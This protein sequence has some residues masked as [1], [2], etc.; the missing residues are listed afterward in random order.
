MERL[1]ELFRPLSDRHQQALQW[2]A[3]HMGTDQPWP[4][5]IPH[6]EGETFL[7]TKA[8]GIYKPNWTRYALSVRQT[9]GGPYPDR[10]PVLRDDGTWLYSYFQENENPSARDQE[11]TNLGL[12]ACLRD[13]V[14]IGVLRQTQAKPTVRYRVLGLALVSGWDAGYFFLEGFS[15]AGTANL[16]GP[17]SELELFVRK[18]ER[19]SAE[20]RAFEPSGILDS[21]ERTVAQ[22]VRRRGQPEF[23]RKL[24]AAYGNRCA[25]TGCDAVEALEASHI[26]P[27]MG[28]ETNRIVNGLLLRADI[29]T[30]FDMGLLAVQETTMK[31][32]IAPRMG[33]TTYQD[34]AGMDLR[35]PDNLEDRPSV[36]AL[37]LHREWAGL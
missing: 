32:L 7:A 14:P 25:I 31:I 9:L 27:Y 17:G 6:P 1:Q 15:P 34:L 23:R 4:E 21:R 11:F 35:L 22:I 8:K 2:F 29:H 30:L 26:S 18:E 28:E 10:D 37:R 19:L 5:P 3:N 16:S 24:L 13:K 12:M 36:A 20:A 33:R